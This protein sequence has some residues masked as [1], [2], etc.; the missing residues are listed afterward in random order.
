MTELDRDEKLRLQG[1]VGQAWELRAGP[2]S[3][4]AAQA[5][6]DW[7]ER[8]DVRRL[9]R[10]QERAAALVRLLRATSPDSTSRRTAA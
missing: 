1:L 8:R 10:E 4:D 7:F 6:V 2:Y 9:E 5:I 3:V